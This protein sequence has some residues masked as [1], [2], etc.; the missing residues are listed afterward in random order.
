MANFLTRIFG[1]RN[2]RLVKQYSKTVQKI[3][4]LES[5]YKALDDQS[6]K[7]K[8]LEFRDQL[9][10]GTSLDALLPDA[11]ATVRE[12]AIRTLGMRQRCVPVKARLW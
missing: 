7:N 8:T 9:N 10:S 12:A 2:Q 3:N 1:S 6:L 5:S 11:F 4:D